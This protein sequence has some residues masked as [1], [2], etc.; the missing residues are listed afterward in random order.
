MARAIERDWGFEDITAKFEREPRTGRREERSRR[1]GA[2]GSKRAVVV[3]ARGMM[4]VGFWLSAVAISLIG[5]VMLH[6]GIL[7]KNMEYN[8]LISEKSTLAADNAR[9]SREVAQLRSPER[10]E[11]IATGSLGMVPP[12]TVE[13]VY[14]GPSSSRQNFA[15]IDMRSSAESR[16]SA[17]P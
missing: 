2:A 12:Q 5:L 4:H 6:V 9:L 7:S 17:S 3:R 1:E 16:L 8:D 15:E 10:I 13:Y 14:I 11:E